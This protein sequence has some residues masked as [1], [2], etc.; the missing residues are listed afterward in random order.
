MPPFVPASNNRATCY[1]SQLL[2]LFSAERFC[3]CECA[4]MGGLA[5][6]VRRENEM[7]SFVWAFVSY[8]K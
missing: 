4:F 6:A 5:Y 7:G 1:V 3:F 8:L 2:A